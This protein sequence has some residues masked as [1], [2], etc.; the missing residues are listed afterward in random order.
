VT[1]FAAAILAAL[2]LSLPAASAQQA[3]KGKEAASLPWGQ[4]RGPNRD[5]CSTETGLLKQW[6]KEG[7][8]LAWKATGLGAGFSSVTMGDVGGGSAVIA[9]DPASGKI[10]WTTKIGTGGGGSGYP[11]PRCTPATDGTLV[12]AVNQHG[13]LACLNAATGALVWKK[14]MEGDLGGRVMSGWGYS[15]SPLLDGNLLIIT[16]GGSRGTVAALNKM[17]GA[18][19]WQSAEFK[20]AAAYSSLIAVELGK[21]RQYVVFTGESVAGIMATN[22]KLLW[23]APRPGQTAICS[24]PVWKDGLL[25]V[26]SGYNVGCTGF[27]VSFA[28]NAFKIQQLYDGKQMKNHHGGMVVVGEHVYG[29]DEG[30]LK[31]IDLKTGMAAWEN[32]SVGKGSVTYADGN[33]VCRAEGG[34][35][36]VALV[37]ADPAAYKELGRFDQPNRSSTNS[38]A[39]PAVI[40]GRLYL[41][42]DDVLLCY[43]LKA[44]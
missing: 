29:M 20:D 42:D 40:G 30:T 31:C 44:K 37:A 19:V 2:L 18:P 39:N 32:R 35:G 7:P 5:G 1:R 36:S 23:K 27:Q 13:D 26:S 3:K 21:I 38:W 4:F 9:V 16:P 11:G 12:W 6:P 25:F 17:N 10:Q 15:E 24:T 43:D 41:R 28:G 8:P 34:A 14:S 22:G 33:L